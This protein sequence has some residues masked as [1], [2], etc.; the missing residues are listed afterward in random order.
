MYAGKV[1]ALGAPAELKRNLTEHK[2]LRLDT[3]A[4][5][6]TMRAIEHR[7]GV[8]EVAVFGSGLHVVVDD[9]EEAMALIRKELGARGIRIARLERIDPSLEDVFV[10]LIEAEERKAAA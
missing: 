5:L 3:P 4:P 6:D 1:I 9:A 7:E 10:A 8:L 2:L